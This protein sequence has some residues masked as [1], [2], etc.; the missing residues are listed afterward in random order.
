M[1]LAGERAIRCQVAAVLRVGPLYS[2]RFK[3]AFCVDE[4]RVRG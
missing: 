2:S 4:G 1:A 3:R